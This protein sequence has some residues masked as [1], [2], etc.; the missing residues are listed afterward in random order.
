MARKH[1]VFLD[2]TDEE[3][4]Y[5]LGFIA[6][7]GWIE[8][9]KGTPCGVGIKLNS[10][11]SLHLQ[12]FKEYMNTKAN[13]RMKQEK[14]SE[15]AVIV[16]GGKNSFVPRLIRLGITP[17][18]SKTL[19]VHPT[20]ANSKHFWRGAL[21]GDGCIKHRINRAGHNS[22][23]TILTSASEHFSNQFFEY[24]DSVFPKTPSKYVNKDGVYRIGYQCS[25][26][27]IMVDHF[28]RDAG[29]YLPRKRK[30]YLK[31]ME[32]KVG[33]NAIYK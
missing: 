27:R 4:N 13:V 2:L 6:T 20:L 12:R 30:D 22:F 29:I 21:D 9:H 5:W 25:F 3:T 24:C 16:I 7:D 26:S 18:K 1:E 32:V 33:K 31:I 28:Y 10:K 11:D 8:T 15:M 17:R 14:V 23:T 19:K